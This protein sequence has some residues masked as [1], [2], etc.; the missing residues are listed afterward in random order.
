MIVTNNVFFFFNEDDECINY[1]VHDDSDSPDSDQEDM[2]YCWS[3]TKDLT[4]Q[5]IDTIF[6]HYNSPLPASPGQLT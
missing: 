2:D 1:D 6:T 3:Q 4:N 5:Q